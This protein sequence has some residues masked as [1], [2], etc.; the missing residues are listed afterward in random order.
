MLRCAVFASGSGSNF[1]ALIDRREAG[2]LKVEL[3]LLVGNNSTAVA[4][5]RARKHGIPSVHLAPSR[6]PDEATYTGRL[7]STLREHAIDVIALAGYMK[8]IPRQVIAAYPNRI[9][10]IH[11]ALL[12]S[13]GGPGLYGDRVHQAVLDSGA[14]VS[15]ITVHFVDDEYD[16]GPIICQE[17]VPVLD[18]DDTHSL[19]ARVLAVEHAVYW[20]A[21]AAISA[22]QLTV[23][24]RRVFG[25]V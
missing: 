25:H 24:G 22:G 12:P 11:P 20:K 7:L 5:E 10:N 13:F 3:A 16:H 8:K 6:F 15:G 17:I 23:K 1:Q 9:L 14:K 19:A 21:L 18:E 2:D 4:F